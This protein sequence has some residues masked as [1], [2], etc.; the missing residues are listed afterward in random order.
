MTRARIAGIVL[1]LA[2]SLA[3][4]VV[5]PYQPPAETSHDI[6]A[7]ANPERLRLSV[8]PRQFLE[9]MAR[10]VLRENERL[11]QVDGQTFIDTASPE[12]EL[13]LAR[14]LEPSTRGLIGP[15]GADYLVLLGQPTDKSLKSKGGMLLHLGF[16]GATEQKSST[17]Y[18]A[19]VIDARRLQVL[20]QLTSEATGTDVGVGLFYGLFVVSDTAGSARKNAIREIAGAIASAK[21]TGRVGVAFL[22]VEPI[23]SAEE[24]A[25]EA[26]RAE[27]ARVR[28]A[29]RWSVERFPAFEPMAPP[30]AG[31]SLVYLYR[32]D[33][34]LG[35]FVRSD[36]ALAAG[37]TERRV[38]ALWSGGYFPFRAPAGELRFSVLPWELGREAPTVTLNVEAG[39]TYYVEASAAM[40]WRMPRPRLQIVGAERGERAVRKCGRMPTARETDL[41]TLRR[42]EIGDPASQVELA[43]LYAKGA[44]YTEGDPLPRDDAEAYK[45]LRIAA[46]DESEIWRDLA[47]RQREVVAAKLDAAQIAE[48]ERR[49]RAWLESAREPTP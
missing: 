23:P 4:C 22:A 18:W 36:I 34:T 10:D 6:A 45:W 8:G 15:L 24:I 37:D 26:R 32:P 1:A 43:E 13:T 49:A 33:V 28:S 11:Q 2:S 5:I 42:A 14:L 44:R 41:E 16:F 48:G 3:G 40:G 31:Q 21:P 20:E 9:K 25:A 27:R 38:T 35:R 39:R 47:A 12:Q 17:A 29:P 19:A 46:A 30:P 7:I